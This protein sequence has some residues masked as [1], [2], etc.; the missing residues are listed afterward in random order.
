MTNLQTI[1]E[2]IEMAHGIQHLDI[3][4]YLAK[5]KANPLKPEKII[6]MYEKLSRLLQEKVISLAE[7]IW[8]NGPISVGS[9]HEMWHYHTIGNDAA[10]AKKI[11]FLNEQIIAGA[12]YDIQCAADFRKK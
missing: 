8:A 4:E 11:L 10:L 6:K 7:R 12:Y 2:K 1:I 3:K 9:N 5:H